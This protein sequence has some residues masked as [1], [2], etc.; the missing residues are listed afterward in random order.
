MRDSSRPCCSIALSGSPKE[1]NWLYELKLD[2]Y[3]AL[4][5]ESEGR[6]QLRSRNDKDFNASYPGFVEALASMPW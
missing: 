3:R 4:A 5:L 6:L 1:P 2:G